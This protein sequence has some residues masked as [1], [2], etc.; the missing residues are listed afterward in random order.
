MRGNEEN[1]LLGNY[2]RN[3]METRVKPYV[4]DSTYCSYVSG[5][6]SNF[7]KDKIS[8]LEIDKLSSDL[9]ERYYLDLLKRKGRQTT[10]VMVTLTK[11]LSLYLF[12]RDLI[13]ENYASRVIIPRKTKEELDLEN[14]RLERERK[15]FFSKEDILKFYQAYETGGAPAKQTGSPPSFCSWKPIYGPAS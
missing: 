7:Y 2:M 12:S 4:Q 13:P 9:L 8:E 6:N 15:K 14:I 1:L 5:L 11:R 3:F 10:Q